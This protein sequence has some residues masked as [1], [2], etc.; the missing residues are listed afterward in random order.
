MQ[1][2][3]VFELQVIGLSLLWLG[4]TLLSRWFYEKGHDWGMA[5]QPRHPNA[6]NMRKARNAGLDLQRRQAA[7]M[8]KRWLAAGQV[9]M[10]AVVLI[11]AA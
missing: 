10:A 4:M 2:P 7:G 1:Y 3:P 6:E 11:V 5:P 9:P 8:M